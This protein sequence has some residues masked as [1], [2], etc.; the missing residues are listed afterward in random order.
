MSLSQ[1]HTGLML[2]PWY[3]SKEWHKVH[4]LVYSN[5][6]NE[7]QQALE[8][9]KVWKTRTPILSTGVEGTL[10]LLEALLLDN[11]SEDQ[12]ANLWA[13]ALMRFLNLSAANSEKQGSFARISGKNQLP[14][15]LINLRHDIAHGHQI[16]SLYNLKMGLDF[17]INWLKEKYW[18]PQ[19]QLIQDYYVEEQ[20]LTNQALFEYVEAYVELTIALFNNKELLNNEYIEKIQLFI[21]RKLSKQENDPKFLLEVLLEIISLNLKKNQIDNISLD[22]LISAMLQP[23]YQLQNEDM[24]I[25]RITEEFLNIWERLLNILHQRG[26]L[27]LLV[28]KLSSITMDISQIENSKKMAALWINELYLALLSQK[29][30][31]E[32]I[33]NVLELDSYSITYQQETVEFLKEILLYPNKYLDY[34]LDSLQK[35]ISNKSNKDIAHLVKAKSSTENIHILVDQ[36]YTLKNLDLEDLNYNNLKGINEN[37]SHKVV[38][39]SNK[40]QQ[41]ED[42][43]MFKNCPLGVMP[44][45]IGQKHPFLVVD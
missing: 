44:H 15:W 17:G 16:P 32:S 33:D 31:D 24:K 9:L 40:W 23:N 2:V 43:T 26:F 28:K 11:L 29:Y 37:A 41:L 14:K 19:S 36:I 18:D 21:S 22:F 25:E 35:Y 42:T 27:F 7:R 4:Q 5:N 30:S 6:S 12:L 45:Q 20:A 13:I 1:K 39:A 10:I 3:N 38:Q 8:L 34:Y